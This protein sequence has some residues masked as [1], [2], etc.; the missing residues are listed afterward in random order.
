MTEP[1]VTGNLINKA[2]SHK[3]AG[4]FHYIGPHTRDS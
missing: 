4:L 1:Y 2:L 3:A